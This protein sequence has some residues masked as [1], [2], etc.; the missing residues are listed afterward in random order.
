MKKPF[1]QYLYGLVDDLGIVTASS[2]RHNPKAVRQCAIENEREYLLWDENDSKTDKQVWRS[3]YRQ[4]FRV[5]PVVVTSQ[6]RG[7]PRCL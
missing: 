3:I 1:K 6:N 4:G 2:I 7:G 5:V